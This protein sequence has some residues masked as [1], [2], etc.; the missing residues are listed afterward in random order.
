MIRYR[1]VVNSGSIESQ[2]K[3]VENIHPIAISKKTNTERDL[4]EY[5]ASRG[6]GHVSDMIRSVLMVFEGIEELLA[7]GEIVNINGFGSFQLGLS[8]K[9]NKD[10]GFSSRAESIEIKS[11]N[12]KASRKLKARL[13]VAKFERYNPNVHPKRVY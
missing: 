5:L 1:Y 3:R 9:K 13:S 11:V 2:K 8:F 6:G 12:L 10:G 4:A 7:E